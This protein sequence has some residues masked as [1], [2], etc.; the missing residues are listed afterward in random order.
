MKEIYYY[1]RDTLKRPVVT[2]C[3]MKHDDRYLRGVSCCSIHDNPEKKIGR[4]I[5]RVRAFAQLGD[6]V[7]PAMKPARSEK[8]LINLLEYK[9]LGFPMHKSES[10]DFDQ[11]TKFE[12]HLME[13]VQHA[14]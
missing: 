12:Q 11:L 1:V 10:L 14:A 4:K 3:L 6:G 8:L 2:V 13:K 5:A 7:P 9:V